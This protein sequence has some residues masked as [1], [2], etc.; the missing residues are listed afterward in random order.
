MGTGVKEGTEVL[1]GSERGNDGRQGRR[2]KGS[3]EDLAEMSENTT[4]D[5]G[6]IEHKV[7]TSLQGG[8]VACLVGLS[9]EETPELTH[10]AVFEGQPAPELGPSP[11]PMFSNKLSD[12]R[13][14][15]SQLLD[16]N[17]P[18]GGPET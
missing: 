11:V 16:K 17:S 9:L 5:A 10:V 8:D 1:R 12:I 13:P 6:L 2:V 18:F 3:L 7:R 14:E 15:V 4:L